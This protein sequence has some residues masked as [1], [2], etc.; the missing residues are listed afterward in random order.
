MFV[1]KRPLLAGLVIGGSCLAVWGM[2]FARQPSRTVSLQK[3]MGRI[4]G[5]WTGTLRVWNPSSKGLETQILNGNVTI[6]QKFDEFRIRLDFTPPDGKNKMSAV[7]PFSVNASN[8]VQMD[9]EAYLSPNL[10]QFADATSSH[11][12]LKSMQGEAGIRVLLYRDSIR[13]Q[14]IEN[15]GRLGGL[16][17][18]KKVLK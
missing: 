7:I 11:F 2:V 4:S 16:I 10:P 9:N 3:A 5:N 15:D 13:I 12:E 1:R 18:A 14:K 6:E 17:L 8:Q